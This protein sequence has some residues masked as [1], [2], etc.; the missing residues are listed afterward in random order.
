MPRAKN[1]DYVTTRYDLVEDENEV[2]IETGDADIDAFARRVLDTMAALNVDGMANRQAGIEALAIVYGVST[3]TIRRRLDELKNA[4]IQT[5]I[6][7]VKHDRR[8]SRPINGCHI[9]YDESKGDFIEDGK[10]HKL[11]T[12]DT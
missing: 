7:K 11:N 8:R 5:L 10:M 12:D 4:T 2:R 6:P 1:Y 9:P 3:R